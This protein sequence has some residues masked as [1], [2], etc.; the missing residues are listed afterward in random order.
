MNKSEIQTDCQTIF[1]EIQELKEI[2]KWKSNSAIFEKTFLAYID[3]G[4][5]ETES[6]K[7]K[8]KE[9]FKKI[10]QRV[11]KSIINKSTLIELE[12]LREA[13]YTCDDYRHSKLYQSELPPGV[14]ECLAEESKKLEAWLLQN[15]YEK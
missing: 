8:Y 15:D 14:G 9:K 2:L 3:E 6:A 12:K 1:K 10:F 5:D 4:D 11:Q 7:N 13:I